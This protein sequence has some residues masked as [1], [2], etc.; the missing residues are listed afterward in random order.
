MLENIIQNIRRFSN[1]ASVRAVHDDDLR[2][3]LTSYGVLE[4]FIEGNVICTFCGEALTLDNLAGW[5]IREG[6]PQFFCDR[7]GC[8]DVPWVAEPPIDE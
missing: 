8:I 2:E 4:E 5:R 7:P 1:R 6:I 3:V